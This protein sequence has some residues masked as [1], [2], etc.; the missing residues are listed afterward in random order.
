MNNNILIGYNGKA[1][2]V[3]VPNGVK[4][5]GGGTFAYH[6]ELKAITL[7]SSVEKFGVDA[8]GLTP[9]KDDRAIVAV[10]KLYEEFIVFDF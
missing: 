6:T 5:I 7:P 10:C 1:S 4:S 2:K 9:C 8:F 3:T